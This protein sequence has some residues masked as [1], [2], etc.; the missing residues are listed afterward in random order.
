MSKSLFQNTLP[1]FS[2]KKTEIS[3]LKGSPSEHLQSNRTKHSKCAPQ[4]LSI[5]HRQTK[6]IDLFIFVLVT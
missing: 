4:K 5:Q 2:V 1:E 6:W 3:V